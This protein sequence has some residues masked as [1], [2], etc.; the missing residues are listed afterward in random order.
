[1]QQ[2]LP[3]IST[4]VSVGLL[5][6][7]YLIKRTIFKEIDTLN[8]KLNSLEKEM[9]SMKMNYLDRFEKVIKT[10]NDNHI[11][12]IKNFGEVKEMIAEIRTTQKRRTKQ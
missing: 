8:T 4:L 12:T 2:F 6:I 3:I 1:M 9:A 10:A 11:E 7:G 5:A